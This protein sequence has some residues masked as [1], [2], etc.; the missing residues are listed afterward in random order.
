MRVTKEEVVCN[1]RSRRKAKG[2]SQTELAARVGAKR[3]AIYDM[4]TGRYVPNT[5]LALRIAK[6]LNCKV[7]D[8]F[9]L[10]D[11]E[12]ERPVTLVETA[13]IANLRVSM[14]RVRE[15]LIAYPLDG[16]WLLSEGFQ[17]ADGLLT[18]DCSHVQLL[19]SG[20]QVEKK[21][22][23]LGCDPAFAILSAHVSRC[24][25]GMGVYC[26]FA[27]SQLALERLAA[28]HAHIAGTHLHNP[29]S[30]E[31]NVTLAR[32]VLSGSKAMVIAFSSFEEGLI[33]APGNPH[34]IRTIADLGKKGTRFV[35]R[36]PGAALR[37]LLDERLAQAGLTGECV[38]GYGNQVSSHNLCAQM[39]AFNMVDAALGLRAIAAIHGLDFVPME[40][41]R[42]DL[43]I[44]YDFLDL[45]AVKVL[46]DVLQTRS[47]RQEL[48]SLPGYESGYTGKVIGE[49]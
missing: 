23:L 10:D 4:E 6:E 42:C 13:G 27:S 9:V 40:A 26:R 7:E 29:P 34:G 16:K 28:G 48:S 41:V 22:L 24:A 37:I 49:V 21:V 47:L 31:S 30:V 46:L 14:A 8:L 44:P 25:E 38:G 39:V 36:E 11:S 35:N 17:A 18:P 33:V 19:Q 20:K 45:P 5:A 15:R 1:L 3:Q 32:K 43:V 2:L 12:D